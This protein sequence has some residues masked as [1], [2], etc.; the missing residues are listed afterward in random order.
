M[1]RAGHL[2][3]LLETIFETTISVVEKIRFQKLFVLFLFIGLIMT[4][5]TFA[6]PPVS[7]A[8]SYDRAKGTLHVE[9]IHPSFNL[10]KSYIRLMEVYVNG[11]E[12][13]TQNYYR[14]DAYDKFTDDVPLTVQ[15]GDVIKVDLFAS[16]GGEMAK[17]LMV[18][19]PEKE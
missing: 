18:L 13:L 4:T 1:K 7:I 6:T 5:A 9:A 2:R 16:L 10:E 17:E 12:V 8:L 19:K 3:E 11:Q 14:Q 15:A